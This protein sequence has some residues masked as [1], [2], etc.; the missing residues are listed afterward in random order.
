M[1]RYRKTA[2]YRT[3]K[4]ALGREKTGERLGKTLLSPDEAAIIPTDEEVELRW[5]ASFNNTAIIKDYKKE[6]E[7]LLGLNLAPI[8]GRVEE[9]ARQ[10]LEDEIIME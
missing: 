4:D 5:P 10:E 9:L 6:R 8:I 1:E 2:L 7:L 3:V